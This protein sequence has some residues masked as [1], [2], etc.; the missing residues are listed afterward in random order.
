[1]Q[2]NDLLVPDSKKGMFVTILVAFISPDDGTIIYANAGHNPPIVQREPDRIL[3]ELPP[4]G[5]AL[6]VIEGI[7]IGEQ[8]ITIAPG[9]KLIVYTDGVTEAFSEGNEIF[10]V[11]RLKK[12][13]SG[14][15]GHSAKKQLDKIEGAISKFIAN[16]APSD[17]LTLAA[18][19]RKQ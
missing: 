12:A 7:E 18:F 9:E 8:R 5:M 11:E 15:K 4:T 2:V 19:I 1:M 13:I 16:A 10:G 17:D 14:Y 6:G 3:I